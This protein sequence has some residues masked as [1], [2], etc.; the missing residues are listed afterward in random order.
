MEDI[1]IKGEIKYI[2]G[3]IDLSSACI[4]MTGSADLCDTEGNTVVS[5]MSVTIKSEGCNKS[6]ANKNITVKNN[7][8]DLFIPFIDSNNQPDLSDL[9]FPVIYPNPTAKSLNLKTDRI[10]HKNNISI[11]NIKGK[12]FN[13]FKFN[14][15]NNGYSIDISNLKKGI[16]IISFIDKSDDFRFTQKIIKD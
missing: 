2:E 3:H 16:Y 8:K 9:N 13:N 6:K 7:G 1:S 14:K 11:S 10:L 15:S 5:N 4:T 12:H